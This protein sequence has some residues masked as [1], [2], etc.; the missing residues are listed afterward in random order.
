MNDTAS[1]V[2][3]L[4]NIHFSTRWWHKSG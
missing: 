2:A 1:V 3:L 4:R